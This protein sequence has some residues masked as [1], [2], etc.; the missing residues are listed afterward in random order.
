MKQ[1]R[2]R[3][4]QIRAVLDRYMLRSQRGSGPEAAQRSPQ[5]GSPNLSDME[6]IDKAA[7]A[8][9]GELFRRLMSGDITG[10]ASHSEADLALCNILAFFARG[11]TEQIDRIFR[12][13]GLMRDKWDRKQSGTT[14]GAITIAR[15]VRDCKTI[16]DPRGDPSRDFGNLDIYI[17]GQKATP[18]EPG[19][20]DDQKRSLKPLTFTDLG[21]AAVFVNEYGDRVRYSKATGFLVYDGS[22]WKENE[23]DAQ[24][25]AQAL[26]VRQLKEAREQLRK[27][28]DDLTA[29]Q[30][31]A[32]GAVVDVFSGDGSSDVKKAEGKVKSANSYHSYVLGRQKSSSISNTLKEIRPS[33]Q[34]EVDKLD[35][36]GLMLNT[37]AGIVDLRTGQIRE[38]RAEDYCTKMTGVAPSDKNADLYLKFIDQ[39]TCGDRDLARYLQEVAGM[40]AIGKVFSEKLIIA[41]GDGGNGKSTLFNLWADVL[42]DYAGTIPSEELIV[43]A[44]NAKSYSIANLRGKRLIIAA[45]LREGARLSTDAVKKMCSTD[46]ISAEMKYRDPFEFRPSHSLVLYTNHLPRV[47]TNDSGTW[48]RLVVIPFNARFRN[49]SGE[50]KNYAEYLYKKCGGAVLQWIIEGAQRFIANGGSIELPE[51]VKAEIEQYKNDNDWLKAFLDDECD[52]ICQH[53][54]SAGALYARY[55]SY[56]NHSGDG[57]PRSRADFKRALEAAG[58]IWQRTMRGSFYLGLRLRDNST[59]EDFQ[60]GYEAITNT[61]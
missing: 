45:E 47:N 7:A 46:K 24:G 20:A 26:T 58:F 1:I 18:T 54:E 13:S 4:A 15:A 28:Q 19:K 48:D 49:E 42:G 3:T 43:R 51:C 6:L 5:S 40:C 2:E 22:V 50:I 41:Y 53:G 16:Y 23:L 37:P 25:L 36:D 39:V 35:A 31:A 52:Q 9:N 21:Q 12:T 14:Y 59:I 34:I 32:A 57:R 38:H 29:A 8:S 27:A 60:S 10:Y 17:S 11:D 44:G 33:V 61:G 30:E 55:Q 56:C